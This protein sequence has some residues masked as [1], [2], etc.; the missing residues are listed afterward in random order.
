MEK[1]SQEIIAGGGVVWRRNAQDVIEMALVHRVRYDD[2]SLPK[3]KVEGEESI[4][5]CAYRE[6]MEETGF[7]VRF[8]PQLGTYSYPVKEQIKHV[9]YWSVKYLKDIGTP[10]P[11]EVDQVKWIVLSEAREVVTR[12]L[13][14]DVISRFMELDP[15]TK[16]LVL[17]RHAQEIGRAHV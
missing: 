7:A 16:P 13:D 4:I 1:N 10:N 17:L 12:E 14:R 5:A 11:S 3:G 15:D 2:W 9:T 6:I 8:G